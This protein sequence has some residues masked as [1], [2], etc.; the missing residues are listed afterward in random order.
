[1][2]QCRKRVSRTRKLVPSERNIHMLNARK[3]CARYG[4]LFEIFP[5][6]YRCQAIKA[7]IAR[8]VTF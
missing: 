2:V 4:Q 7:S 5:Q 1:M 8:M 3:A 6:G